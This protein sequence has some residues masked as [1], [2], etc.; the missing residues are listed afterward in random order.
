MSNTQVDNFLKHLLLNFRVA[1][2]LIQGPSKSITGSLV[3]GNQKGDDLVADVLVRKTQVMLITSIQHIAKEILVHVS[4]IRSIFT[5]L[6]NL[7]NNGVHEIER[8]V[9][10]TVGFQRQMLNQLGLR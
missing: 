8:S 1:G 6:N 5:L 7:I 2:Q 3:S 4:S 10:A 9:E